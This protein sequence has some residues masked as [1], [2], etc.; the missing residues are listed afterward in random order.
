MDNELNKNNKIFFLLDSDNDDE[1]LKIIDNFIKSFKNL[2]IELYFW[3]EEK[4]IFYFENNEVDIEGRIIFADSVV[5]LLSKKSFIYRELGQKLEKMKLTDWQNSIATNLLFNQKGNVKKLFSKFELKTP[6]FEKIKDQIPEKLFSNFP[7][8]SR[9]FSKKNNFFSGKLEN[10][11]EI[12]DIFEKHQLMINSYYIEEYLEGKDVY[13]LILKD[14]NKLKQYYVLDNEEELDSNITEN[15]NKITEKAFN[16]FGIEKYGLFHLKVT[17]KKDIQFLNI[18][19]EINIFSNLKNEII[20]KIFKK[21]NLNMN[22][23]FDL[24]K[25]KS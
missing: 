19:T 14:N 1:N 3:S 16:E 21:Y 6:F 11:E 25:N 5:N 7:Q 17:E 24:I 8:P 15:I 12:K 22:N 13:V 10:A 9:I 2:T 18:F 20:K 23:T 4:Q